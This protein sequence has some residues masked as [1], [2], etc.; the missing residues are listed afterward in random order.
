MTV[1]VSWGLTRYCG[2][3][4]EIRHSV[5]VCYCWNCGHFFQ[6]GLREPGLCEY[7][8]SCHTLLLSKSGKSALSFCLSLS[9]S[10]SS[11]FSLF[12]SINLQA[13]ICV[14]RDLSQRLTVFSVDTWS[15]KIKL[16]T[17]ILNIQIVSMNIKKDRKPT[18]PLETDK[19]KK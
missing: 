4:E 15:K 11:G 13:N 1:E 16:H 5:Q 14:Q 17:K 9:Q 8:P 7:P 12:P 18:Y 2:I 6:Q 10:L 19:N 3:A